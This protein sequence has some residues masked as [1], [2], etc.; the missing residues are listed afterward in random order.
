MNQREIRFICKFVAFNIEEIDYF[1]LD[2]L[3]SILGVEQ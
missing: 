3:Y 2:S 1:R